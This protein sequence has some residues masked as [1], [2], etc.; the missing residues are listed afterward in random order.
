MLILI[1][2]AGPDFYGSPRRRRGKTNYACEADRQSFDDQ[3]SLIVRHK[4]IGLA[5]RR[6]GYVS[7]S[8]KPF[9]K[10]RTLL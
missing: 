5:L 1:F 4:L 7:G 8:E 10:I 6:C 3:M 2:M 9:Y